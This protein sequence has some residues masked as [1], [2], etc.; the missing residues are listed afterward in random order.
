MNALSKHFTA[1][2]EDYCQ[3]RSTEMAPVD[4]IYRLIKNQDKIFAA[5]L[6]CGCGRYST[7]LYQRLHGRIVLYCVDY[8]WDMLRQLS[9]F[10]QRHPISNF[11][12]CQSDANNIPFADKSLDMILIFNAI[13]HF[14][15]LN[16]LK[17]VSRLL[18]PQGWLFIYTRTRNQNN[19]NIWGKFFP[20]FA[21]KETRLYEVQEIKGYIK[22]IPGLCFDN[23]KNFRFNKTASLDR[24][25]ELARHHHYSTF[26]LYSQ[27]QFKWALHLFE[28]KIREHFPDLNNIT[29]QNENVLLSVRKN[30]QPKNKLRFQK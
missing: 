17:E 27:S 30:E 13:H 18:R 10:L 15:L 7:R 6:G 3:L 8:N 12:L 19:R 5:D 23:V 24:L 28:R 1:I 20:L 2:A 21:D 25:L 26:S 4:Y 29:W 9:R 16:F 14:P 11:Y 22:L